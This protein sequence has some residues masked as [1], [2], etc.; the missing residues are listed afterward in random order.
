MYYIMTTY[1]E[2]GGK[3]PH[4]SRFTP[5]EETAVPIG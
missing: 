5:T 1:W 4:S 2:N 3:A